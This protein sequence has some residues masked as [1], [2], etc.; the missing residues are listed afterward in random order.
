MFVVRE[1]R[2]TDSEQVNALALNAFEQFKDAAS[3]G[4]G[5]H[6]SMPRTESS[7]IFP[8]NY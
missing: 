1:F 5:H 4:Q 6:V 2:P 7:M 3:L 8:K